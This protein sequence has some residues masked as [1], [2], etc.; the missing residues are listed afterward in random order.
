MRSLEE[1]GKLVS[2]LAAVR[3]ERLRYELYTLEKVLTLADVNARELADRRLYL[4]AT[5][6]RR[7]SRHR[8]R[9]PRGSGCCVAVVQLR[10]KD[11]PERRLLELG[12]RVRMWTLREAVRHFSS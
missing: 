10:E 5:D 8:P 9:R 7:P 12:R 6:L 2:P 11:M 4:L 3:F 1:F